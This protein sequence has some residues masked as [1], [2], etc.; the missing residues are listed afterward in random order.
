MSK[1]YKPCKYRIMK[2]A[3]GTFTTEYRAPWQ[4][5]WS[6]VKNP[7]FLDDDWQTPIISESSFDAELVAKE[8][9]ARRHAD[10]IKNSPGEVHCRIEVK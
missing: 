3:D 8:H 10:W 2:K 6:T 7:N 9:N 1:K 4:L 5:G